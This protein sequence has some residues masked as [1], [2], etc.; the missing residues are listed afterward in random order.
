MFCNLKDS[1]FKRSPACKARCDT[2]SAYVLHSART[3]NTVR[4]TVGE[5]WHGA[6]N[7]RVAVLKA[8][9]HPTGVLLTAHCVYR[10]LC[11][12]G[13]DVWVEALGAD[14]L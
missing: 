9:I 6:F 8:L 5:D 11:I 7:V 12:V 4:K 3:R 10:A 14:V 2:L 13:V 1:S